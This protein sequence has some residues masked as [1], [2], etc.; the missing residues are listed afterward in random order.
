MTFAATANCVL[1]QG[2]RPVFADICVDTLNI[3]PAEIAHAHVTS[4]T[5]AVLPVDYA[6][7]PSELDSNSRTC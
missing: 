5:R 3:D 2:A 4:K 1:Y 6:G 7:H